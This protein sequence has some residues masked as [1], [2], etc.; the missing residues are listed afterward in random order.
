[1]KKDGLSEKDIR[2]FPFLDLR[3]FGQ[4]YEITLPYLSRS[5]RPL[6]FISD[7]H[8]AHKKLYSYY[9]GQRPVE[10]VN[11]R[12]K[13]VG[14]GKKIKL[15]RLPL[16]DTSPEKALIKKQT[17]HY[18]GKPY[19]ASVFKRAFLL[20][21]NRMKGPALIADAESTTFLPPNYALVVDGFLNLIIQRIN[22]SHG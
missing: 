13:S 12:V 21:G 1:M 17:I 22:R 15:K 2:I 19:K 14:A 6:S 20:P 4:S 11:I 18:K 7:F 5:T 16:H 8:K 10:I 9:H 3:Y